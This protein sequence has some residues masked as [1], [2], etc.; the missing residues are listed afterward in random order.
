MKNYKNRQPEIKITLIY[1]VLGFVWILFSGNMVYNLS[2]QSE[3]I[4]T[5]ERY[6]GW[7]FILITGVLLFLLI[8]RESN[9]QNSLMQQLT[10]S[11]E[12]LMDKSKALQSQ[13]ERLEEFAFITSHNLRKP[14]ANILG[15]IQLFNKNNSTDAENKL[16]IEKISEMADELDSLVRQSNTFL[17]T[18]PEGQDEQ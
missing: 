16:V 17:E 7:F 9:K 2:E 3:V 6:K 18:K 15:L 11:K 1:F 5:L 8:K 13:N 10:E 12:R 4:V 14:L